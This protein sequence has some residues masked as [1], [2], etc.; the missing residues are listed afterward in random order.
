MY[1][2]YAC[3]IKYIQYFDLQIM[4]MIEVV[5]ACYYEYTTSNTIYKIKDRSSATTKHRRRSRA[6]SRS[7]TQAQRIKR[8]QRLHTR[9]R[10][11]NAGVLTKHIEFTVDSINNDMAADK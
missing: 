3:I 8:R 9:A 6:D 5:S 7:L 2:Y 10:Q 1:E 4:L 11:N